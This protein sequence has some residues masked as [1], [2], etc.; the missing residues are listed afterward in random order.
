MR[1]YVA[2]DAARAEILREMIENVKNCFTAQDRREHSVNQMYR[3]YL[4]DDIAKEVIAY[5]AYQEEL[6][7]QNV[8]E[9]RVTIAQG[10]RSASWARLHGSREDR[11]GPQNFQGLTNVN[12][13]GPR[14]NISNILSQERV[15][16]LSDILSQ[17]R[18]SEEY[19]YLALGLEP[20]G[21][22]NPDQRETNINTI[23]QGNCDNNCG[24]SNLNQNETSR[25]T[26]QE[27]H[28]RGETR[29]DELYRLQRRINESLLPVTIKVKEMQDNI[30]KITD[31]LRKANINIEKNLSSLDTEG[32]QYKC[33]V[34]YFIEKCTM[35]VPCNHVACCVEC[36]KI[37]MKQNSKCPI[38]NNFAEYTKKVYI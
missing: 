15:I 1:D 4:S 18:L 21:I 3:M 27:S 34:C 31:A 11:F 35:F 24:I 20:V 30:N 33:C 7:I 38:C 32:N 22:S 6:S 37:V 10:P 2:P 16:G 9:R 36:A 17:E 5:I 12:V 13:Q 19:N 25:S 29:A 26:M 14:E 23:Q 8:D 28:N